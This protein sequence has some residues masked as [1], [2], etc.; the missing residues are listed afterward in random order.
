MRKFRGTLAL[1]LLAVVILS[2]FV[3]WNGVRGAAEGSGSNP[4]SGPEI[5][6]KLDRWAPLAP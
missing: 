6:R 2:A 1:L 5:I 4:E 3:V